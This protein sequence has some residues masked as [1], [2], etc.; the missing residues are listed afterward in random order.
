MKPP[1]HPSALLPEERLE[2]WLASQPLTPSPDFVARTLARVRAE[3]TLV[4]SAQAGDEAAIDI[5][6]D[7]WLSEQSVEPGYEPTQLATQTRRTAE[8]EEEQESLPQKPS[9]RRVVMF[10]VWARSAVALA[11][12]AC[13]VLLAYFSTTNQATTTTTISPTLA[14]NSIPAADTVDDSSVPAHYA[15]AY[16]PKADLQV[17]DSLSDGTALLNS[18]N[19]NIL[20]GNDA[21][22]EDDTV[23]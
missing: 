4:S 13:V 16:D 22:T 5:L 19:D 18:D 14:Q 2:A 15:F 8:Y 17:S 1:I 6:I 11:A 12:A 10:P 7:R 21:P 20:L 23:N 3:T 9:K